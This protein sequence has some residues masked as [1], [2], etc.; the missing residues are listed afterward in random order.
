MAEL[1]EAASGC[2]D[3][4]A[5]A[6]AFP[7]PDTLTALSLAN[8]QELA[9]AD[10]LDAISCT[11]RLLSHLAGIQTTLL[12]E[13]SRPGRAGD[14][15][16]MVS[17]LTDLGGGART[18]SGELDSDLLDALVTDRAHGMAAAEMAAALNI[19][20]ITAR[21]R[22]EKAV[23]LHDGLP[24]THQAL[25]HG[26]IDRGRAAVIAE[27][28]S[29][30]GPDLRTEVEN[31]V[32]PL[33]EGRTAGRLRPLIDRAVIVADPDAAERRVKK[34]KRGREV[35]HQPLKDQ[36]SLIRAVMP[37]DNAVTVYTLID[38]LA[39]ATTTGDERIIGERRSDALHDMCHE[40]LTHGHLDLRGL[41]DLDSDGDSDVQEEF[42]DDTA[43]TDEEAGRVDNRSYNNVNTNDLDDDDDDDDGAVSSC[44]LGL[45]GQMIGCR[46]VVQMTRHCQTHPFRTQPFRTQPF[47]TQPFRTTSSIGT[48]SVRPRPKTQRY[49]AN[50]PHSPPRSRLENSSA[51][52]EKST[53]NRR[54]ASSKGLLRRQGRRPH[55]TLTMSMSTL[56]ALD[57][58]PGHLDGYGAITAELSAAIA[59]CAASLNLVVIDPQT[60]TPLHA[61]SRKY[62]RPRQA[63]RDVAGTLA[64]NCRFPSCRQPAWR[65]D[66]DHRTAYDHEHPERGG[67]TSSTNLDPL[68]RRHHLM[69]HHSDWK[70]VRQPDGALRWTSP[71]RHTYTD[72]PR[73]ITLP[74][75]LLAPAPLPRTTVGLA[76][77][78]HQT[79]CASA[80]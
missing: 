38:L 39:A 55:L 78:E 41:L 66:L 73:E 13:F 4:N 34:A 46:Q 48:Y 28:T 9:P 75:E 18:A 56:M 44:S 70:S 36:L 64:E 6:A 23:D 65:C 71:T 47:R 63:D 5:C 54:R 2:L 72:L 53:S 80:R 11:E 61:S 1:A 22:V 43:P 76:D 30:L 16:G 45:F 33:A 60:G 35:T 52:P 67:E 59:Y 17:T 8:P 26:L 14:I 42:W 62:Y 10:L 31:I 25:T 79:Q 40:L 74:G 58:L 20:P 50:P 69:K 12:T 3:W 51:H 49:A 68:C 21:H 15:S 27:H 57:R 37:A 7:S 32:L 24:A 77:H 19:S 29:I